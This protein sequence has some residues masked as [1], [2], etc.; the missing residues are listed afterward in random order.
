[1]RLVRQSEM[2]ANTIWTDGIPTT[3]GRI[4]PH[5]VAQDD[6]RGT[7]WDVGHGFLA[8]VAGTT[9]SIVGQSIE[10]VLEMFEGMKAWGEEITKA[11][12]GK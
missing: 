5:R 12:Q 11:T 4:G 7:I 1:M 10:D 6:E 2:P 3:C 9:V 8:K